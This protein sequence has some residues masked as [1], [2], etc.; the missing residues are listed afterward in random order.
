VRIATVAPAYPYRGGIAHFGARLAQELNHDHQQLYLNYTRLYPN[1]LFPG[2]T[3]YDESSAPVNFNS[4]RILDSINPLSWRRTA[5]RIAEWQADVAIFHWWHPFFA[6]AVRATTNKL[7]RKITKLTI[8]HNVAPHDGGTVRKQLVKYALSGMD[9]LIIHSTSEKSELKALLPNI[10]Y[11]SLFHPIYDIF[12]GEEITKENARSALGIPQDTRMVLFFG[13]IRPY[14]GVETLVQAAKQLA[15]VEKLAIYI[16][17]EVYSDGEQLRRDIASVPGGIVTLVDRYLPNEEVGAWFRAADLI[18]LPYLTATQSGIVPLAYRYERPVVVTNVGGLPDVVME[19]KS[20]YLVPPANPVKLANA[21]QRH[22]IELRNPSLIDG[23]RFM[24]NEL[25]WK[26]Y[27]SRLVEFAT[28]L[29][30]GKV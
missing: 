16:V 26:T 22:F 18:A 27:S 14:K 23:I 3:Q 15:G 10:P 13:L 21:I 25:S 20:G 29:Q 17:G 1:L 2:K 5:N 8:C 11:R 30:A 12:P 24:Q 7:P 9:G 6:P 28:E 19:G 4:E